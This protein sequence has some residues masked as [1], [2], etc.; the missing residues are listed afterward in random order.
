MAE[1]ERRIAAPL[2]LRLLGRRLEGV[3]I[4]YN[5][6]ATDRPEL[7]LPGAFAPVPLT[8]PLSLQHDPALQLGAAY[9]VDAAAELR[10]AAELPQGSGVV[11][12]VQ[13]RVLRG[14]SIEFRALQED[15]VAGTRRILKA[16]LE[17]LA[18]VD[19]GSYETE[20]EA[21]QRQRQRRRRV[22]L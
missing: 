11:D 13:R 2:E 16:A 8:V 5:Q 18:V 4:R 20:L 15:R 9:L 3:A 7:F 14:L 22:Y 12:L 6:R 10:M 17:G 1:L 21:R 19:A